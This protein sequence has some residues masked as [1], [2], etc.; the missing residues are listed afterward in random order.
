MTDDTWFVVSERSISYYPG[1][2]F[3]E[4]CPAPGVETKHFTAPGVEID[5]FRKT[6]SYTDPTAG[7]LILTGFGYA[8]NGPGLCPIVGIYQLTEKNVEQAMIDWCDRQQSKR[9]TQKAR[10]RSSM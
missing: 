8:Y 1:V 3:T 5:W 7:A 4:S 2:V 6:W 10:P 9:T